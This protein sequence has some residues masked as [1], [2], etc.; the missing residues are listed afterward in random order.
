M[1][2]DLKKC[3][4]C[5]KDVQDELQHIYFVIARDGIHSK[6]IWT[7]GRGETF[8]LGPDFRYKELKFN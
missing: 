1:E 3:P 7:C 2:T 8:T 4:K 5:L 6:R